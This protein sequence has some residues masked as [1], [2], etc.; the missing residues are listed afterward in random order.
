[1]PATR[2]RSLGSLVIGLFIVAAFMLP[3]D[4][5]AKKKK[6]RKGRKAKTAQVETQE[7][8]SPEQI[9]AREHYTK[10]KAL[11]DEKKFAE[12]LTEFQAA[13]EAKS[14]PTVLKSIAECEVAL[15]TISAA[16]ATLDKYLADPEAPDKASVEARVGELK[17]MPVKV[18]ITSQP[19]GAKISVAGTE[20]AEVTPANI[21]L[22]AGEYIVT[23][24]SEGFDP[25]SR[26][27]AVSLEGKNE[28]AIDFVAEAEAAKPD[29]EPLPDPFAA[30][31]EEEPET[32][33]V[34]LEEEDETDLPNAF[35]A[36]AA[37]TGVGLVSGTVFGTMALGDEDDYQENPTKATKE[38]GERNA[39]IADVSFGVAGA[40]AIVGTV[41]LVTNR[42]KNK[43]KAESARIRVLP[44]TGKHQ[45]GL[46]A[47]VSF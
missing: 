9:E 25:V 26:S 13:Y 11:Y 17:N 31:A 30:G 7:P 33:P 16:I 32:A 21:E 37:I 28:L 43:E 34:A 35:W 8:E 36:F 19:E 40:A 6:K 23:L 2:L 10:G 20:I 3:S 22:A 46:S 47:A 38:A 15:G 18:A 39:L 29:E 5:L 14:H 27:I 44:T 45:F 41:I 12:A 1:M 42:K 24:S 4:A